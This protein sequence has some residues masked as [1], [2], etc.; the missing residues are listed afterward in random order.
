MPGIGS[1]KRQL[2]NS[3]PDLSN[4]KQNW[5]KTAGYTEIETTAFKNFLKDPED[6][7]AP[8]FV[9]IWRNLHPDAKAYS[10]FSYRFNCRSKGIGWRIDGSE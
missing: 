8:E 4:P 9:D 3:C 5:N 7:D 10:Y 1:Y 6:T 2:S